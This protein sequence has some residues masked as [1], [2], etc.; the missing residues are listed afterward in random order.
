MSGEV[1]P[2]GK[3]RDQPAEVLLADED[4]CQWLLAQPWFRERWPNVYNVVINYGAEPQDSP[5]HNQ[6]QA[7]YLDDARCF[8]LADLAWPSLAGNYDVLSALNLL[9]A[10]ERY[11]ALRD[12]CDLSEKQPQIR[13]RRFED[14]GWD[15]VFEV[16][17]A[18]IWAH[19]S[20]PA[21]TCRCDHSGCPGTSTCQGGRQRY[22]CR[23]FGHGKWESPTHCCADC[24]WAVVPAAPGD[25]EWLQDDHWFS[26][27]HGGVVRAELKPDLGD[28]YPSVLRQVL[29]YKAGHY[30]K[31]CVVARRH[32]FEH[33]T[34]DQ[35]CQIFAA[36]GILLLSEGEVDPA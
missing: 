15:A 6:M 17:A 35:V 30:D 1:V 5:E 10:D 34:W 29:S 25:R 18:G 9:N 14:G 13:Q 36:S 16:E 24:H 28:D 11:R 2:F 12:Y 7:L 20:P 19:P 4:Y 31:R 26:R 23:H 22:D 33:V 3:Y 27:T 21:C 32:A 8:R